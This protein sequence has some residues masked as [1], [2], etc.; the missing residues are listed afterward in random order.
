MLAPLAGP[1]DPRLQPDRAARLRR[2]GVRRARAARRRPTRRA[3]RART[4]NLPAELRTVTAA[5]LE[6]FESAQLFVGPGP[7]G[8]AGLRAHRRQRPGGR[9]D[10]AP[11]CTGCRWRS[12]SP[13]RASSCCTPEQIVARLEDH[14]DA[15]DGGSR[16]LPE[17]QQTLRGAIAWSYDLLEPGTRRLL[18]RLAVFVGGCELDVAD[19]VCGPA[20]E[21]GIDVLDG[22]ATLVD[23][24]LVRVEESDDEPALRDVRHDPR[25]RG[26]D[27]RHERRMRGHRGA[28][29]PGIPRPGRGGGAAA[30]G[31]RPAALARPAGA[32]A[33]QPPGDLDVGRQ[34]PG[35]RARGARRVRAVA[36]LAAA[37][38]PERGAGPARAT[39]AAAAGSLPPVT[40]GPA[41]RGARGCRL[42]AGG[43][44]DGGGAATTEAL[45]LWRRDRRRREIANALYNRAYADAAWIMGGRT[46]DVPRRRGRCSRRRSRSTATSATARRGQHPLGDGQLP[47]LRQRDGRG[48]GDFREA[49]ALHR[50]GGNR[51][52]EAWSLHM[53]ALALDLAR[54]APPKPRRPAVEAL[55]ALP[56]SRRRRRDHARPRR[57]GRSRAVHDDLPRA[58]RLWGAARHLQEIT[59]VDACR[60]FTETGLRIARVHDGDARCCLPTS[61]NATRPKA[62]R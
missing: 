61:S 11:G 15:A 2:A 3:A 51:T 26:R 20:S 19:R 18:N 55:R 38:L 24:S 46:G 25:V 13:P 17:R 47:L 32:R 35:S 60:S 29:Q 34:P 41:R 1:A 48:R 42:L 5:T 16:D 49:L 54:N 44:G 57:P 37:R 23:Q 8:A 14:L 43:P 6:G 50:S 40:A 39:C 56:R 4:L 52:M 21:V 30:R 31:R 58:G 28:P 27:A 59:G 62:P 10:H 45:A 7:V 53:L 33:R 12:S 36:V 9:Q 22:V